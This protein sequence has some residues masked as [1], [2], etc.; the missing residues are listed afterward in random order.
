MFIRRS[1]I[2]YLPK[3]YYDKCDL[4]N[5]HENMLRF[6][7]FRREMQS[8]FISKSDKN[9]TA[10]EDKTKKKWAIFFEKKS[11]NIC[12]CVYSC[13]LSAIRFSCFKF[14]LLNVNQTMFA[15]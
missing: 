3:H 7:R 8:A 12:V 4:G 9:G 15:I 11:L 6:R 1:D 14:I 5:Q 13:P 2:Y 10:N